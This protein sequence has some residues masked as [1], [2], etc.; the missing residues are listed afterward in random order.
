MNTTKVA[1]L[2]IDNQ[3]SPC[4]YPWFKFETKQTKM[5]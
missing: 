4:V 2:H 3:S 5:K 1:K